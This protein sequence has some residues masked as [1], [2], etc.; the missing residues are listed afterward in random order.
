MAS[1]EPSPLDTA[2]LRFQIAVLEEV[3]RQAPNDTEALRFLSHAYSG[4]GRLEEGLAADRRL[5]E[6]LPTDPRVRYNLACSC[7]LMQ[8]KEEALAVLRQACELGFDDLAL[9]Q[10]DRD[11]DSLR[12]DPRYLEI[13]RILERRSGG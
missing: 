7:A 1:D 4:I 6:L 9:M 2:S 11:L 13:E 12:D 8:R 5:V 10:K 3:L